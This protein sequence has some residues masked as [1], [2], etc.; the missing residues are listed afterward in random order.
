[1]STRGTDPQLSSLAAVA[2][3]AAVAEVVEAT[4]LA[5]ERGTA[6]VKETEAMEEVVEAM[7]AKAAAGRR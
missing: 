6:A 4:G 7:E 5:V 3:E 1:M 2:M